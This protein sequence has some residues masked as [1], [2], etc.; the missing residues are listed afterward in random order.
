M[1]VLIIGGGGREHAM[2]YALHKSDMAGDIY[3]APGNAGIAQVATC[4]PDLDV[5]DQKAVRDFMYDNNCGLCVIGPEQPLVD[6]LS[7]YLRSEK[8]PVFGPSQA[9]AQLEASKSFTKQLCDAQNIP[10]AAYGVFDT[11]DAAKAY[12]EELG[13]KCVIKA[14]GLAAGKGVIMA[15]NTAGAEA[16]IEGMFAGDFG[17]A[18]AK[19]VV[20]E[21]LEGEEASFFAFCDGENI[22]PLTTA[23]DHK[24]VGE[25]D[26]GLNTGGMGAYSPAPVLDKDMCGRVLKEIIEPTV[27]GMARRGTPYTG[28]LFAGLMITADG[29]KLIEYNARFGDPETQALMVRMRSDLFANMIA[30][31]N[32]EKLDNTVTAW[33]EDEV[34]VTVVMA[35]KGYPGS[36]EKGS[37]IKGLEEAAADPMVEIFHAGTTEKDG[38]IIAIGGRVLNITARGKDIIEAREKAYAAINKIYWP[39]G[40]YRKDIGWRAVERLERGQGKN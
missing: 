2:A 6:G 40:F 23:Q 30:C 26:T 13:T 32:G 39:E 36:Y 4:L 7:D 9:A 19:V 38:K 20:E 35:A 31:A 11:A 21:W 1:G 12:V 28:V 8:I 14:D 18:G 37:E 10:T 27:K 33:W 16:A 34:S 15:E 22:L 17:A 24:R 5:T 25:G 29:P 3:C